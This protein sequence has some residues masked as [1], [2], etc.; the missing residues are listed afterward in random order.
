VVAA[1]DPAFVGGDE[2]AERSGECGEVA[3]VEAAA[4]EEA[5]DLVELV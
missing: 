4:V 3:V 1:A 2:G 5:S